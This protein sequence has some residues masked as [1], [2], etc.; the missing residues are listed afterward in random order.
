MCNM[1]GKY[2]MHGMCN[3]YIVHTSYIAGGNCMT[4]HL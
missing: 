3:M 2:N 1:Y 4:T